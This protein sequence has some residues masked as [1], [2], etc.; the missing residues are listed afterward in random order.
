WIELLRQDYVDVLRPQRIPRSKLIKPAE[1]VRAVEFGRRKLASAVNV[2]RRLALVL[3]DADNDRPCELAPLLR[4]YVPTPAVDL[5]IV[6]A[7]AEY[8]TWFVCAADS[9]TDYLDLDAPVPQQPEDERLRK[10]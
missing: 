9:L 10:G 5:S 8:E 4:S 3:L 7:N 1:L 2:E 6:V